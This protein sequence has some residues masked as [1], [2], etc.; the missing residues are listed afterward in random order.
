VTEDQIEYEDV[1]ALLAGVWDAN[2]KLDA[3]LRYLYDDDDGEEEEIT[4]D[5]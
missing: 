2:R 3:I 4:P 5:A 1:K